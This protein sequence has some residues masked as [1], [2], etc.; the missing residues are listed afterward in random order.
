MKTYFI[1]SFT[2]LINIVQLYGQKS[3]SLE[4]KNTGNDIRPFGPVSTPLYIITADNKEL[5]I[6]SN[7]NSTDRITLTLTLEQINS[8]WIQSFSVLRDKEAT[9]QYG[10]TGQGGVILIELKK[11]MFEKMPAELRG[12]FK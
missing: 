1:L 7:I 9:D 11:G 4:M 12:R 3:D 8:N 5:Q 6:A 10:L 2:I